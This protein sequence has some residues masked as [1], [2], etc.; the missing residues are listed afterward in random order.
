FDLF[1]GV[2]PELNAETAFSVVHIG[3]PSIASVGPWPWRRDEIAT[4]V[5]RLSEL[6][7]KAV[8]L[9]LILDAPDR[10]S[11]DSVEERLLQTPDAA[12]LSDLRASLMRLPDPDSVLASAMRR[13]PTALATSVLVRS[14]EVPQLGMPFAFDVPPPP[15]TDIRRFRGAI[16]A[17]PILRDAAVTEGAINLLPEHDSVLRRA[18]LFFVVDDVVHPTLPVAAL[19]A[20]GREVQLSIGP[21]TDTRLSIDG[22]TRTGDGEGVVWLDFGRVSKIPVLEAS[23]L[24]HAARAQI[25]GRIVV[26]GLRAA[27]LSPSFRLAN[28]RLASGPEV[29]ATIADALDVGSMLNRSWPVT[30]AEAG[31]T[32]VGSMLVAAAWLHLAPAAA[33]MGTL[34]L[35]LFWAA[36]VVTARLKAGLLLDAISPL[37]FWAVLAATALTSRAVE[38]WR[39]RAE[40]I[41][42]LEART[43]AA[44][45]ASDAKTRFLREMN[46][47]LRTPLNAILGFSSVI[48]KM[49]KEFFTP[50]NGVEY[51]KTISSA[52]NLILGL[53]ERALQAAKMSSEE[54]EP[55]L[56]N[57]DVREI[58]EEAALIMST[59]REKAATIEL[60]IDR[61]SMPMRADR[62]YFLEAVLNLLENAIRHAQGTD[63]I[64]LA[65]KRQEGN[66]VTIDVLDR[67]PGIRDELRR[68]VGTPFIPGRSEQDGVRSPGLGLY[69]VKRFAD[70]HGGTLE[71]TNRPTGGLRARIKL[72]L[73][74][75]EADTPVRDKQDPVRS[76]V[77]EAEASRL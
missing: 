53:S 51:A 32:L 6:G 74:E 33:L 55:I 57:V 37:V 62:T 14:P 66:T 28:G 45:A 25:D 71:L 24:S 16:L 10:M 27:G 11:P 22:G 49:P 23:G 69:I 15:G 9:N 7:A 73:L 58:V 35:C 5:T 42:A 19:L 75:A 59:Q 13:L 72:S 65:A 61:A 3:E 76:K 4:I 8:V 54:V 30:W 26:L 39:A 1:Q 43:I 56:E 52:G 2:S 38:L 47:D 67:G 34:A 44:E 31:F 64:V 29:V 21:R 68:A 50:E 63:E 77:A 60:S 40:L 12:G 48:S 20:A 36:V 70:M 46:H 41:A 18:P 17:M